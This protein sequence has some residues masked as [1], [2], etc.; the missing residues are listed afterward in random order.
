MPSRGE[1]FALDRDEDGI[2]G[3]EGVEGEEI[4]GG[5]TVDDD[6]Y[7]VVANLGDAFAEVEL[8]VGD[9]HHFEVG[10]DQVFVGGD[11]LETFKIGGADGVFERGIAQQD[12]VEAG[13]I[14]ILGDAEAAGTVALRVGI[15]EENP[16][17]VSGQGGGKVNGGG[18]LP[19]SAFLIGYC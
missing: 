7:E 11:D 4:E 12:V 18:G 3:E 9:V 17:V 10:A 16:D 8:A 1:E 2:G 13:F 19:D 6:E 5:G 15:D 14:G